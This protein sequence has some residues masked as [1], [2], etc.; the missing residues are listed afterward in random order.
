MT[1]AAR[2]V[3]LGIVLIAMTLTLSRCANPLGSSSEVAN[4]FHPGLP[5]GPTIT[6]IEPTSGSPNGRTLLT[7]NGTGFEKNATV[8]AAGVNCGSVFFISS[9][10]VQCRTSAHDVGGPYDV[11]LT[12]IDLQM[13]ILPNSYTYGLNGLAVPGFGATASGGISSG[14]ALNPS[15]VLHGASSVIGSAVPQTGSGIKLYGGIIG[16]Y[17]AP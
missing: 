9:R 4:N 12:N 15:I 8:T 11:V 7:V 16:I 2:N 6:S 17:R 5:P 13:A 14:P 10:Q 3:G 1:S